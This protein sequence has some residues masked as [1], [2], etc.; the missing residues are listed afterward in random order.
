MGSTADGY[1]LRFVQTSHEEMA[2]FMACGHAEFS[3]AAGVCLATIRRYA[4]LIGGAR[5]ASSPRDS[6]VDASRRARA[7]YG[8]ALVISRQAE[9]PP[10]RRRRIARP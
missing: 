8:I 4:H 3:G 7:A 6:V 1:R 5:M 10:K 9:M 2:A